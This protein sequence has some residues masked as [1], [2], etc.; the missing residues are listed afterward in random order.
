MSRNSSAATRAQVP[1]GRGLEAELPRGGDDVAAEPVDREED[2]QGDDAERREEREQGR[3]AREGEDVES[4]VAGEDRVGD[5]ERRPVDHPEHQAPGRGHRQS[6]QESEPER[7][8]KGE[9]SER[10]GDVDRQRRFAEL[11]DD[12]MRDQAALCPA[13]G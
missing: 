7:D 9:P 8:R 4:D 13:A 10:G 11:K 3:E 6:G 2:Q 1:A 5:A 12:G